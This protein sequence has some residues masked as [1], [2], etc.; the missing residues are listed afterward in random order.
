MTG[1]DFGHD[2]VAMTGHARSCPG[3]TGVAWSWLFMTGHDVM[4]MTI[5]TA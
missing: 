4:T 3:M 5:I 2:G 1:H